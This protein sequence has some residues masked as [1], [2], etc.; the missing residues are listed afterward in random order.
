MLSAHLDHLGIGAAVNGDS[1][2]NGAQDNAV[3][4]AA[5]LEAGR[6]LMQSR[7]S[8]RRSVLLLATTAE[9]KG[10]L[11]ADHFAANP[12]VPPSAIVAN[13][14]LDMPTHLAPVTDVIP[15]G[16]EHSTLDTVAKAAVEAAGLT[17]TP[18]PFPDEVLF[19]RSDQ[20]PFIRKGVPAVYLGA[21]IKRADDSD[22]LAAFGGFLRQHYHKPS[23]DLSRPI[24]WLGAAQL[25]I[26]NRNIAYAIATQ[27]ARP[28]W[29]PGDF[30]GEKF[31]GTPKQQ[32]Q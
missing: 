16:I 25:A 3:G 9:E 15:Y 28:A 24:D 29:K 11:G 22:G 5:M 4:I 14:N 31:G 6:L 30:F 2:Y 13:V 20:Y 18:D 32:Q 27:E 23:D 8:M 12:T 21:G 17:L 19:I 10:L 1:I 7:D 26:V